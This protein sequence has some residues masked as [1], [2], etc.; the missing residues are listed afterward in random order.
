[1]KKLFFASVLAIVA[2]GG[3][4]S[5]ANAISLYTLGSDQAIVCDNGNATCTTAVAGETVYRTSAADGQQ[6]DIVQ[7]FEYENLQLIQ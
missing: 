3:A 6:T 2:I 4:A 1:M 5:N 7:P